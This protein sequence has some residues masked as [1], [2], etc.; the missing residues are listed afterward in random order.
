MLA[1]YQDV[2]E[3]L[4]QTIV[5]SNR[6]RKDHIA[7][8]VLKKAGY[9]S[10]SGINDFSEK[11]EKKIVVG[12]YRLTMKSN[13]DKFRQS[14]IQGI[15]KREA[16]VIVFEPTLPDGSCF[17]GSSVIND[18]VKFKEESDVIIA[19]R[20]DKELDDIEEKV[21]ARDVFGRD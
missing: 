12:V 7:D 8:M 5:N 19:N 11:A 2:P 9:Y 20:Q 14:S 16:T 21:F 18:L 6:T 3:N 13:S 1:N 17:F 4:I 10:Y 15:M